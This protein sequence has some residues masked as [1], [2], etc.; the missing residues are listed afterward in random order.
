MPTLQAI[1]VPVDDIPLA[2]SNATIQ[3]RKFTVDNRGYAHVQQDLNAPEQ[4]HN[5]YKNSTQDPRNRRVIPL[6]TFFIPSTGGGQ[7]YQPK[8]RPAQD[9]LLLDQS[10]QSA[11]TAAKGHPVLA[12]SA[13]QQRFHANHYPQ[14]QL[15]VSS[16]L[17]RNI[18]IVFCKRH[19][20][21]I[22]LPSDLY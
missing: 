11:S 15:A 14:Q 20:L 4:F 22:N 9:H 10:Q 7:F 6:M 5:S 2:R 3:S 1:T 18:S 12:Q 8:L 19:E 13:T 21:I 17:N 16:K